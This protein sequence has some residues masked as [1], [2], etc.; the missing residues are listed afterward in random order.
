MHMGNNE[1]VKRKMVRDWFSGLAA[2][3]YNTGLQKLDT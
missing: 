1:E 3:F 2:D